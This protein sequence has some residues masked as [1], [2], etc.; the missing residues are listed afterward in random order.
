M[1]LVCAGQ[2][3]CQNISVEMASTSMTSS[4][5]VITGTYHQ[6]GREEDSPSPNNNSPQNTTGRPNLQHATETS[7]VT[8]EPDIPVALMSNKQKSKCLL[9]SLARCLKREEHTELFKAVNAQKACDEYARVLSP[10]SMEPSA[11]KYIM[12]AQKN[13]TLTAT[14][15][16]DFWWIGEV[17]PMSTLI[18]MIPHCSTLTDICSCPQTLVTQYDDAVAC[19]SSNLSH[20]T[21]VFS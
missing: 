17:R 9:K 19:Q 6:E 1:C 12:K 18:C 15:G 4:C 14:G 8:D 21:E 16:G 3:E 2:C 5:W 10:S 7:N 13:Y 11:V 20:I